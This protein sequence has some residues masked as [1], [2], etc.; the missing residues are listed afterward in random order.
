[1]Y[2][3]LKRVAT[4]ACLMAIASPAAAQDGADIAGT[5]DV[6]FEEVQ[7][8]CKD[9]G[10]TLRRSS[11]EL[12]RGA[13]KRMDVTI[14]MVPIMKGV[15]SK[16]GKFNAKAKKGATAIQGLDGKFSSSGHVKD[17]VL[18]MVFVAEYFNGDEPLCTQ[19]WNAS[20]IKK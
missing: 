14:P 20:G 13:R 16:G 7:N 1:M 4:V 3:T 9:T 19:S 18:Q 17:G 15:A 8:S 5:Y 12:S 10:M 2:G 6:K 11:V